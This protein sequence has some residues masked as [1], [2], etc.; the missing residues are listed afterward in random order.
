M[1]YIELKSKEP[2][3]KLEDYKTLNEVKNKDSYGR[4]LEE[5]ELIVDIDSQK[6]SEKLLEIVKAE[7]IGTRVYKT[8]RGMHFLFTNPYDVKNAIH[9]NTPVGIS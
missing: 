3:S 9:S 6:E 1:R 7:N 4:I 8:S 2:I 5:N